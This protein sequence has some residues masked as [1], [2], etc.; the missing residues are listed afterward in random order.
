MTSTYKQWNR[1]ANQHNDITFLLWIALKKKKKRLN[2]QC[3]NPALENGLPIIMRGKKKKMRW[4]KFRS[5][6]IRRE[7]EGLLCFLAL[8]LPFIISNSIPLLSDHAET[9]YLTSKWIHCG[10]TP[11][12]QMNRK[13]V[14]LLI[15]EELFLPTPTTVCGWRGYGE[16]ESIPPLLYSD[17]VKINLLSHCSNAM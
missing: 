7:K 9:H 5:I 2:L 6:Q 11:Q 15:L 14:L 10:K 1:T 12:M 3:L 16:S 17:F 8:V 4:L 13:N